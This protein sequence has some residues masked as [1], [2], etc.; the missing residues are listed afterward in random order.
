MTIELERVVAIDG[1]TILLPEAIER[2]AAHFAD[3][4][5]GA[6]AGTVSVGNVKSLLTRFQALEY[7]TSQN[8][9]RRAF[10]LLNATIVVPG[11][12]GAWRKQ[13]MLC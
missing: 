5:V 11:A 7:V 12:I 10:A 3:P 8:M 2:L 4:T 1:D 13:A 6:I 9:D